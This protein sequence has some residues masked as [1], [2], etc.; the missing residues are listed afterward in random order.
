MCLLPDSGLNEGLKSCNIYSSSLEYNGLLSPF[1]LSLN[2][3]TVH[4]LKHA[5]VHSALS[6]QFIYRIRW[7]LLSHS[8]LLEWIV[9]ITLSVFIHQALYSLCHSLCLILYL[10]DL[11][12]LSLGVLNSDRHGIYP[13]HFLSCWAGR[14]AWAASTDR[15]SWKKKLRVVEVGQELAWKRNCAKFSIR[16][17]LQRLGYARRVR[18]TYR[19]PWGDPAMC[20]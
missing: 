9:L 7:Y 19:V 10:Q 15:T 6:T 8:V 3:K 4:P 13:C 20:L 1:L 14:R 17:S 16:K 11:C 2:C 5:E 12:Y 18:E